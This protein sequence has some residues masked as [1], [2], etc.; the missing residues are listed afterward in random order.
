MANYSIEDEDDFDF[1]YE[2]YLEE[3]ASIQSIVREALPFELIAVVGGIIS[4]IL[5][6]GMTEEI[7]MIPG[8]LVLVPGIMG[9]RGNISSSLGS[10]L[11][12]AIH[13]G[14]IDGVDWKNK[15]LQNN[16]VGSMVLTV[17]ISFLLGVLSHSVS[18]VL[19]LQSAGLLKL[20]FISVTAGFISGILL[21]ILSAYLAVGTF[22][23][24]LDP[25]NI[26]TPAIAT[27]GDI[28]SM[29][30]IFFVARLVLYI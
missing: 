15:E 16:I 14:L 18:V 11:T 22:R 8:L 4:G 19:G 12:S 7:E 6:S 2:G 28:L 30:T 23:L 5:L 20:T 29:M 24:G 3:Y 21:A 25:D 13:M 1:E 9:L 27:V 17:I 10:R 26:V